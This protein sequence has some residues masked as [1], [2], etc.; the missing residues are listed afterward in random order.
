MTQKELLYLEDALN[1]CQFLKNKFNEA[2]SSIKDS[3][4]KKE[5][6]NFEEWAK[7]IFI[8]FFILHNSS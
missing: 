5:A 2:T 8:N 6:S 1:H 7:E 4:L 3:A